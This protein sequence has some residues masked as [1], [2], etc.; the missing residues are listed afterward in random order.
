MAY[1]VLDTD[2]MSKSIKQQLPPRLSARLAGRPTCITF[3][4]FGEL[5]PWGVIHRWGARR[6]TALAQQLAQVPVLPG[7]KVVAEVDRHMLPGLQPASRHTR[8]EGLRGLRPT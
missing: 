7:D 1:I 6:R 5:T 2:V 3:V 8:R 4:T